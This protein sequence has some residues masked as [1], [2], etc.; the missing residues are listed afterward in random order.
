MNC[1]IFSWLFSSGE[2]GGNGI[3]EM[4]C[5]IFSSF[6]PCHKDDD[7][8]GA[9]ADLACDFVEMKLHGLA[10]AEGQ[11]QCRAGSELRAHG[12]EQVGRLRALVVSGPRPRSPSSPAI[13]ELVLLPHPYLVLEPH[14]YRRVRRKAAADF[15]HASVE[16]F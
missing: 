6:A 4:L 9:R 14:F 12:T 2:R 16:F 8:E 10:V 11:N 5:G 7:G 3:S 15:L 1:Q 13:G